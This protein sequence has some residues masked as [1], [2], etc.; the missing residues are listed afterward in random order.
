MKDTLTDTLTGGKETA[1]GRCEAKRS[2]SGG[3][4]RDILRLVLNGGCDYGY[5]GLGSLPLNVDSG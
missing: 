5:N 1:K 3:K 2:R 4:I